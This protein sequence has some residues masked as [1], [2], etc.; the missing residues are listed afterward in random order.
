MMGERSHY[1]IRCPKCG[2]VQAFHTGKDLADAAFSCRASQ[3]G[4]TT[5]LHDARKG[6]LRADVKGP[7]PGLKA[8]GTALV[9]KRRDHPNIEAAL[10]QVE[11]KLEGLPPHKRDELDPPGLADMCCPTDT[12]EFKAASALAGAPASE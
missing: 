6:G 10:T 12:T 7:M 5:K 8:A 4:R 3:C 11:D 1:V 2:D 9:H